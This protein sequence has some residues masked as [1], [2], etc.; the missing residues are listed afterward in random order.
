[1]SKLSLATLLVT[2]F[3]NCNCVQANTID[4][5]Q[6]DLYIFE[7]DQIN[8]YNVLPSVQFN[9][10]QYIDK[11][12]K[13]PYYKA[14]LSVF[15]S[16]DI[17]LIFSGNN[18]I[19]AP[20]LAVDVSASKLNLIGQSKQPSILT[21]HSDGKGTVTTANNEADYPAIGVIVLDGADGG[22][23]DYY[24]AAE[25][26]VKNLTLDISVEDKNVSGKYGHGGA[27]AIVSKIY[28]KNSNP[29]NSDTFVRFEDSDVDIN[30]GTDKYVS[31]QGAAILLVAAKYNRDESFV[32][33]QSSNVNIES[34]LGGI[35][36]TNI[37][38]S[39]VDSYIDI[40]AGQI[41]T[42]RIMKR[43]IS[44]I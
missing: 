16:K 12:N 27:G 35:Y 36:L 13:R 39:F 24:Y 1:M 8:S 41:M 11:N 34:S 44:M 9:G 26:N 7:K 25:F 21:I 32:S 5:N 40:K 23:G 3:A 31:G 29:S 28:S 10:S 15:R 20:G 6:T 18:L 42:I 22:E 30:F 4:S 43:N 37:D 2:T 38:L 33:A 17:S 14:G 19:T